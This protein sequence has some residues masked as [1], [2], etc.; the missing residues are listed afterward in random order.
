MPHSIPRQFIE[1][2]KGEFVVYWRDRSTSA[3]SWDAKFIQRCSSEWKR[4]YHK[5]NQPSGGNIDANRKLSNREPFAEQVRNEAAEL[6]QKIEADAGV[7]E[8]DLADG[9]FVVGTNG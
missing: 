9:D 3:A 4:N 7:I 2:L 6:L 1:E 5:W 8:H